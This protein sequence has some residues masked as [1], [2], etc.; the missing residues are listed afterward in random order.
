MYDNTRFGA[1]QSIENNIVYAKA[2][3]VL[4]FGFSRNQPFNPHERIISAVGQAIEGYVSR[5]GFFRK[6]CGGCPR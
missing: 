1:S 3:R 5:C 2:V 4:F 6:P